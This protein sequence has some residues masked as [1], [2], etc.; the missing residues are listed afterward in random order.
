MTQ[1]CTRPSNATD[2]AVAAGSAVR[3][4]RTSPASI[5]SV[6]GAA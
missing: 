1:G 2:L 3:F 5:T 4:E 6:G